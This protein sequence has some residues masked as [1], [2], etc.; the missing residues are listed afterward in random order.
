MTI[1]ITNILGLILKF[2]LEYFK[3]KMIIPI[4]IFPD[5]RKP[6]N[7]VLNAFYESFYLSHN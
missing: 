2:E 4:L 7:K 5:D 1:V 3:N 6:S